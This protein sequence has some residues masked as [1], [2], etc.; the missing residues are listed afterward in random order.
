MKHHDQFGVNSELSMIGI[1]A[2]CA[3]PKCV[4]GNA[5]MELPQK[6]ARKPGSGE[7]VYQSSGAHYAGGI[8]QSADAGWLS[9][10]YATRCLPFPALARC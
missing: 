6:L 5:S 8:D 1:V 7:F 3:Y 9:I 4:N 10:S 2:P